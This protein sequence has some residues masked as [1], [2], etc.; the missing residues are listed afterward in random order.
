MASKLGS[1]CLV[2]PSE[3]PSL[4]FSLLFSLS[5]SMTLFF[6]KQ[7]FAEL[8]QNFPKIFDIFISFCKVLLIV[9]LAGPVQMRLHRVGCIWMTFR[10][11]RTLS[12][13]SFKIFSGLQFVQRFL[14]RYGETEITSRFLAN[15]RAR[16]TNLELDTTPGAHLGEGYSPGMASVSAGPLQGTLWRLSKGDGPD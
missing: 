10:C 3:V 12:K 1:R 6:L 16:Y 14:R 11:V 15:F 2:R 4:S 9:E 5:I 8:F 13:K 7:A